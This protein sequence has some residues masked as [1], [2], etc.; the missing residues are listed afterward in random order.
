LLA[1]PLI[2]LSESARVLRRFDT[3]IAAAERALR[4]D[5]AATTSAELLAQSRLAVASALWD[6]GRDRRRGLAL[7]REAVDACAD[8]PE[9]GPTC[10][11]ADEWLAEHAASP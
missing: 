9:R 1:S 5:E 10:A 2:G 4:I 11:T 6:S 7:A 3:A 8:A